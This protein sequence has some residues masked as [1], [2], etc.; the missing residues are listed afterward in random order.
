MS[1]Y[2]VIPIF[3]D[4]FLH[5][6]HV[7]NNLSLLYV[8]EAGKDSDMLTFDH[9]DLLR[10]DELDFLEDEIILTPDKK[11]LLY[12]H[13]FK[14]VYDINLLNYYIENEPINED[15]NV[16]AMNF[17]NDRFYNIDDVNTVIPLYKHQ[18]YCDIFSE[19]L[20]SIWEKRNEIDFESYERYNDDAVMAFSSIE[21][22]GITVSNIFDEKYKR[23]LS[24][25]K[26]YGNY[27]LYTTTGRPSNSFGG[28]NFAALDAPRRE[29]VIPRN[30]MLIEFDYDACHIRLIA[31]LIDYEF[32]EGSAHDHLAKLYGLDRDDGKKLTFKYLYGG[33]PFDVIQ[34]NPFFDSVND[35]TCILWKEFNETGKIE[36]PIYKR[37][38]FK[39]NHRNIT[40]TKLFNY[41]IQATETEQNIKTIIELQRYLYMMKSRLILYMYDAFLV[42]FDETDGAESLRQ[43]KKI[44]ES[45]NFLTKVK[46]GFNYNSM[47]DIT[48]KL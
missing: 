6:L 45:D 15:I 5:P 7:K 37:P 2:I 1:H 39:Q 22:N 27:F 19:R 10:A 40:K 38:I 36:T 41:Y 28:I 46:A 8:K 43:M 14:Q 21:K 31:S 18:E 17:L 24:E 30:D 11:Q 42:D 47:K 32:P 44:L 9:L 34:L 23:H 25:K 33:I 13:P 16:N 4:K 48:H 35:L 3:S 29:K 12:V 26:L 20:L